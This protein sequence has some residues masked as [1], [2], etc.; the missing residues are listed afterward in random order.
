MP[1]KHKVP[2][3]YMNRWPRPPCHLSVLHKHSPLSSP[4]WSHGVF[5]VNQLIEDKNNVRPG[6]WCV[7]LMFWCEPKCTRAYS[8]VVLK[9]CERGSFP[10]GRASSSMSFWRREKWSEAKAY[11]DS[12]AVTVAG[13]VVQVLEGPTRGNQ[14]QGGLGEKPVNEPMNLWICEYT[15]LVTGLGMNPEERT[16]IQLSDFFSPLVYYYSRPNVK[17]KTIRCKNLSTHQQLCK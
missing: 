16:G 17:L 14:R 8:G 2:C 10:V 13:Q 6:L 4:L 3:G 7:G 11:M 1:I 5:P 9:D 15:N 12:W